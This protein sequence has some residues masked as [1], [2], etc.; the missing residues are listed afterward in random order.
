MRNNFE[1]MHNQIKEGAIETI[2]EKENELINLK[3]KLVEQEIYYKEQ[4]ESSIQEIRRLEDQLIHA[5]NH[6]AAMS[7]EDSDN[8]VRYS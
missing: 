7:L 1:A 4:I 8:E 3:E 5:G 6:A 2:M